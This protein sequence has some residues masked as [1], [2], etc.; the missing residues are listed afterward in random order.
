MNYLCRICLGYM[1][2]DTSNPK[3][4]FNNFVNE[5]SYSEI[6]E[7]C[8]GY[9]IQLE[10]DDDPVDICE[11][12][13]SSLVDFFEF[14]KKC[15]ETEKYLKKRKNEKDNK[16]GLSLKNVKEEIS[17]IDAT[18][19]D[20]FVA[21]S[22]VDE[23]SPQN[24]KYENMNELSQKY[25]ETEETIT[26]PKKKKKDFSGHSSLCPICGNEYTGGSLRHHLKTHEDSKT[27]PDVFPCDTC[28]KIYKSKSGLSDH[29]KVNHLKSQ[30]YD[31][32]ECGEK[33]D[34]KYN[35]KY[36]IQKF[37]TDIR[38][39]CQICSYSGVTAS[40]LKKHMRRHTGEARPRTHVCKYE[41][42]GKSFIFPI[43]LREHEAHA[44][45]GKRLFKCDSCDKSYTTSKCLE[46][47][48]KTKHIGKRRHACPNCPAAFF[49]NMELRNHITKVH[50]EFVLPALG[51]SLLNLVKQ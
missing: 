46:F 44:H 36:H 29:I 42:C 9:S 50:P 47:H 15:L 32:P 3:N 49:K 20:H 28:G 14:K 51:T 12:C 10:D 39:K 35:K 7:F 43:H 33:F 30:N 26:I 25:E 21:N 40:L 41:S 8:I 37:H 11:N 38:F 34:T 2:A 6:Y 18:N 4:V 5:K 24:I 19:D 13:E 45:L 1:E 31:C 17:D 48:Y 23:V 22:N 16:S 27:N